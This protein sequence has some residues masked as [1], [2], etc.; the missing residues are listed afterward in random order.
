[1]TLSRSTHE[2]IVLANTS[3]LQDFDIPALQRRESKLRINSLATA[4]REYRTKVGRPM[5]INALTVCKTVDKAFLVDGQHRLA[6]LKQV[7]ESDNLDMPVFINYISVK[8]EAEANEMFKLLNENEPLP[9]LP[10]GVSLKE[11]SS[12]AEDLR[13]TF[14]TIFKKTTRP[15]RPHLNFTAFQ[16]ALGNL[17]KSSPIPELPLAIQQFNQYMLD[18]ELETALCKFSAN[19]KSPRQGSQTRQKLVNLVERARGKG[20]MLGMCKEWTNDFTSWLTSQ[21]VQNGTANG[22]KSTRR[23]PISRGVKNQ[24]VAQQR[25]RMRWRG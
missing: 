1:M 14:K 5:P 15:Q 19:G 9:Y 12:A 21:T 3:T 10:E 24:T 11:T 2:T 18:M 4:I 8:D 6:A 23:I 25:Q 17:Q 22:P 7:L 13:A 16:E 20:C